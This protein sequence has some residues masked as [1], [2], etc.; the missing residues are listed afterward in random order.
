MKS[1]SETI[2]TLMNEVTK[3]AHI[4]SAWLTSMAHMEHLAAETILGNISNST[5]PEFLEEIKAHAGDEHRHRDVILAIRPFAEPLNQAYQD[6]RTRFCDIIETFIMGYFGNPELVKANNRFAAYVHGAITIEQ[7]PFQ[8][9]SAYIPST[10]FA[11]IREAMQSVLDDETAH[12]QLGRKFRNSLTEQ[13]RLSLQELQSIEKEMCLLMAERMTDL[14]R[15]FQSRARGP[16]VSAKASVRLAWLLGE[17]PAATI[18][19]VQALG[20]SESAAAEHMQQEFTSRG[21][22]LPAQMPEHVEDE[23]RHARMLHRSVLMDRRRLMMVEGYKELDH[24]LNRQ[25]QRYLTRY[26]SALVREIKD[27]DMLYLYGAWGLEMRVFKHYS[28]IIKW[29]DNVGVAHTITSILEDEAEHTQMVNTA[30]NE[31]RLLNPELLKFVRQTEEEIFEKV[32]ENAIALLLEF[33][34]K[35]NFAPPYRHAYSTTLAKNVKV[36]ITEAEPMMELQ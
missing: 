25:L 36:P 30:L 23:M 22:N 13:D 3:D 31:Q 35:A 1:F 34:Q 12:I 9:Y 11:H 17:R 16:S 27:A 2:Q 21:L 29:T 15:E 4:E 33:D 5:P 18:A 14:I 19:W 32:A 26:F 8:I 20:H 28:D 7:F 10:G 24:R 6:L